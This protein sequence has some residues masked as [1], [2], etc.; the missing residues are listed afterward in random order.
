MVGFRVW[1]FLALRFITG[2]L[3]LGSGFGAS[4][5]SDAA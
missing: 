4:A 3:L 1:G 2:F 5:E